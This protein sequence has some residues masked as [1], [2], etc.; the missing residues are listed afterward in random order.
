[1]AVERRSNF[2]R[3]LVV[4]TALEMC[5]C[6]LRGPWPV[7]ST[8]DRCVLYWRLLRIRSYHSIHNVVDRGVLQL[9]TWEELPGKVGR[10]D[11]LIIPLTTPIWKRYMGGVWCRV[12]SSILT[13]LWRCGSS[14][15]AVTRRRPA[16]SRSSSSSW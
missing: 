9:A 14:S 16:R 4:T 12:F 13:R 11:Q 5:G 3:I 8:T 1:M 10:R 15:L 7:V 6:R 2:S